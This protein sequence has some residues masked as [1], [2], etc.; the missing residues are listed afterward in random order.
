MGAVQ[1]FAVVL[2][3]AL[4][5]NANASPATADGPPAWRPWSPVAPAG[6]LPD[7]PL[8][9]KPDTTSEE[10]RAAPPPPAG[11]L[12]Q[13]LAVPL[14]T[15]KEIIEAGVEAVIHRIDRFFGDPTHRAFEEPS[16]RFRVRNDARFTDEGDFDDTLSFVADLR[17]PALDA[18][19]ARASIF[20][21]GQTR[22]DERDDPDDPVR[23]R[24]APSLRRAGGAVELR[25]DLWRTKRGGVVDVGAGFRFRL[26]PPPYLRARFGQRGRLGPVIGHFTQ[27]G[28][29]ERREGFG[30]TTRLDLEAPLGNVTVPRFLAVATIHQES[31]GLEWL[32]EAGVQRT[33]GTRT[34]VWVAAAMDGKTAA[35]VGV[36][37]YRGYARL[38]REL[39][40]RWVYGELEPEILWPADDAGRR[41]RILALTLRLELQFEAGG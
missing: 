34:G 14:D 6:A 20:L 10:A 19:L 4:A 7:S 38:R 35:P 27:A 16:T 40:R 37:R 17:V 21:A 22:D 41:E 39:H 13:Q 24:L 28:F 36:E 25:Y 29:W 33:L 8:V 15:S 2:L 5:A 23:P 1:P 12:P 9:P 30:E 18:A 11:E 32:L 3:L 26:P 31:R